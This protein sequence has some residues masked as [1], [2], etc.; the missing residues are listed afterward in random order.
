MPVRLKDI[1]AELGLSVVTVS[2]VLRKHPDIAEK[3]RNRV[4]KRMKELNYQPNL[5]ARSLSTGRT[6][7]VG[8]VVPDLLHPFFAQIATTLSAQ[9]RKQRYG[10]I[11]S[12]SEEDPELEQQEIE[13]L[14]SR[15]VDVLVIASAQLTVES[16]RRIE[17]EKVPYVLLDRRFADLEANFVGVDDEEV[18][19]LAT[20]HLIQQ[21]CKRIAHIRGPEVST[22][23]GRVLGYTKALA[24]HHRLP[25]KGHIVSTGSSGDHLGESGGYIRTKELLANSVRPDGIFCFNDPVALGAMR[26]ILDAGLRIP[27]DIAVVGCGNLSYSD[28]LRVPLSTIDQ[29]SELIGQR[30]A[31]LALSLAKSKKSFSPRSHIIRPQLVIRKS[32]QRI[33]V[34][35]SAS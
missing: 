16:F 15:R 32:S 30:A 17:H 29:S 13:H 28:F 33:S 12:S 31:S 19:T 8:L 18:G 23:I 35:P 4:L 24:A 6:C 14:L 7:T 2:K 5:T 22:A 34:K 1:A 3:T 9:F 25:L 10:L 11:I 20:E 26:A 21:G 27:E